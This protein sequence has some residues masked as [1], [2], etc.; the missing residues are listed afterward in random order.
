VSI[1]VAACTASAPPPAGVRPDGFPTGVFAKAY[2][3]PTFGPMRLSWVFTADGEWA[4]V[5]EATAG[6]AIQTGPARGRYTVA[7]DLLS[8]DVSAPSFFG[9]HSHR[10]RLDGDRLV[11]TYEDS[12]LPE[13]ADWFAMLDEQP[14]VRVP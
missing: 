10:W 12:E 2:D 11:T 3:D 5:P 14:W 8:I 1:L 6:Q 13:D 7:G 4:E 9:S